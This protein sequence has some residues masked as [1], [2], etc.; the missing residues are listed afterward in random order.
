MDSIVGIVDD[1]MSVFTCWQGKHEEDELMSYMNQYLYLPQCQNFIIM[2]INN[3]KNGKTEELQQI[4]KELMQRGELVLAQ[5][6]NILVSGDSA[7]SDESYVLLENYFKSEEF[8]K[9][10]ESTLLDLNRP[11]E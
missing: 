4:Y 2:N 1:L 5:K 10:L 11:S 3:I 9:K 6:V 7:I 8:Y